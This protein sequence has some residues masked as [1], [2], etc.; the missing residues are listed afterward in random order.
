MEQTLYAFWKYDICPFMLAGQIESFDGSG[1]V[2]IRGYPG[3]LFKP[4]IIL[5]DKAGQDAADK[6]K[7]LSNEYRKEE[8]KL[9]AAYRQLARELVGL[10]AD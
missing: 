7:I 2:T 8:A 9:K 4:V 1:K 3:F 10:P 6:L 5:P